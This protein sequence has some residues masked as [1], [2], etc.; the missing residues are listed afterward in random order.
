MNSFEFLYRSAAIL[1]GAAVG[2][3]FGGWS[4]L[5]SILLAFIVIDYVSGV[6]AAAYLGKLS[7]SIGFHGIAKKAMIIVVVAAAHL[8]DTAMGTEHIARDAVIFFYLAN[9]LLS[10]L[11]NAGKT[12]LPV[13]EQVT[14]MVDILKGGKK[15]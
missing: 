1:L 6:L 12:G 3:L 15:Q 14:K 7:S 9:E 10:I 2:Y 11:E 5:V 4:M 8:A 13:P